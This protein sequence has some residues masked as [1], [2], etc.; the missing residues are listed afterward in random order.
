[1]ESVVKGIEAML[2]REGMYT[3]GFC[4]IED[5]KAKFSLG[6]RELLKGTSFAISFAYRLSD[7]IL[8]D[9]EDEPSLIY[10]F[11]YKRANSLLDATSLKISSYLHEEGFDAV[12]IPA[13][14]IV[15]WENQ[16]ALISHKHIAI[17]AGLGWIGRNNLVVNPKHGSKLRF[18][19]VLT[20][21][22]VPESNS[23]D[24][25]CGDC[26]ECIKS[27]PV[28]PLK[29]SKQSLTIKGAMSY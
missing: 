17:K 29:R 14:Q 5:L 4:N 2:Q 9:I 6:D 28:V 8:A 20:N 21:L 16:K 13:S 10:A 3:F 22:A 26:I 7:K 15:D 12:P 27:C 23:L 18:A 25:D 1:M 19:T 11:H 24:I